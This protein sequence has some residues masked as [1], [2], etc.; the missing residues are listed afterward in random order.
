MPYFVSIFAQFRAAKRESNIETVIYDGHSV[1]AP[2]QVPA[3]PETNSHLPQIN[4][5]TCL[6]IDVLFKRKLVSLALFASK[7]NE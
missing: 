3:T 4:R 2:S 6:S 1:T 7:L 5:E